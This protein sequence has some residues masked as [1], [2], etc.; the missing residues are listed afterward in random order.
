MM[1]MGSEGQERRKR[2]NYSILLLVMEIPNIYWSLK[3]K[4]NK[5]KQKN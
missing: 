3:Q 2:D 1:G 5:Q 4:Q